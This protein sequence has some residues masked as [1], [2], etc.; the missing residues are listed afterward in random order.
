MTIQEKVSKQL[1]AGFSAAEIRTNLQ[2]DGHSADEIKLALLA[3]PPAEL[4]QA[5][6]KGVSAKTILITVVVVAIAI[7]RLIR[8]FVRMSE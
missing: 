4:A 1:A 5:G 6:S 7:Y 3:V 8:L 2:A